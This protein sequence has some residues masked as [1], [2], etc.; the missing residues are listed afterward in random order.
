MFEDLWSKYLGTYCTWLRGALGRQGLGPLLR[1]PRRG[2]KGRPGPVTTADIARD[3]DLRDGLHLRRKPEL[4]TKESQMHS[5]HSPLNRGG[6]HPLHLLLVRLRPNQQPISPS[7][8]RTK[9]NEG[10]TSMSK[11]LLVSLF[12]KYIREIVVLRIFIQSIMIH[13]RI[14]IIR[15][16]AWLYH[17]PSPWYAS[18]VHHVIH[19]FISVVFPS[20]HFFDR[21]AE[22][23][24]MCSRVFDLIIFHPFIHHKLLI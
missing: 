1:C 22:S 16:V 3:N 7:F 15:L 21:E 6:P 24:H 9:K 12:L 14:I 19:N 17:S 23:F 10:A 2:P 8:T 13:H 5:R 11:S 4:K 20:Y 18:V